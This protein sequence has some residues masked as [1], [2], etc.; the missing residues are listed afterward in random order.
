MTTDSQWIE[1][2]AK[3]LAGLPA[4]T[5]AELAPLLSQDKKTISAATLQRLFAIPTSAAAHLARQL[6][7]ALQ[8]SET[9]S[10][11]VSLVVSAL[12]CSESLRQ[13]MRE[14]VEVVCTAPDRLGFSV[15]TTLATARELIQ[16][17]QEEVVIVGYVFTGGAGVLITDLATARLRGV[18]VTLIGNQMEIH[19]PVIRS[20]WPPGSPAPTIFSR[21]ADER[22]PMSALHAKLLLC[23]R[24][25]ALV[26]SA[27][28]SHHGMHQNIEIGVKVQSPALERLRGFVG[29]MMTLGE[30]RQLTW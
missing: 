8:D 27:N 14:A 2:L 25:S 23:D 7:D 28:F 29:A 3:T 9:N 16:V 22:D 20:L 13:P 26:T 21:D 5:I 1:K 10:H 15:R 6:Q 17:S 30:V 24:T 4:E 18:Q 12:A 19:L 11:D